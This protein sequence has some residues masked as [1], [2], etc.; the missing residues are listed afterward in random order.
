MLEGEAHLPIDVYVPAF[1]DIEQV[2]KNP[3][4]RKPLSREN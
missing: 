1:E 3:Q 2:E 4:K